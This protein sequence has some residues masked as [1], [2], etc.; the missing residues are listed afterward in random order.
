M[1][2]YLVLAIIIV[3]TSASLDTVLT[4]MRNGYTSYLGDEPQQFFLYRNGDQLLTCN[5]ENTCHWTTNA[6]YATKFTYIFGHIIPV[7][8]TTTELSTQPW[9]LTTPISEGIVYYRVANTM[10]PYGIR[11]AYVHR[12]PVC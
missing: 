4:C 5:S 12:L 8:N 10:Y 11:L 2:R 3:A 9:D 1:I 6:V 7:N